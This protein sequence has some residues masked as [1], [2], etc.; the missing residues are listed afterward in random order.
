MHA[1]ACQPLR[2]CLPASSQLAGLH[3]AGVLSK[4]HLPIKLC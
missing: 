1:Y 4:H 2:N 3:E